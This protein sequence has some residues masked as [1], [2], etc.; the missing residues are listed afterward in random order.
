MIESI[1]SIDKAAMLARV[2]EI[3]G[4]ITEIENTIGVGKTF[5]ATLDREIERQGALTNPMPIEKFIE[6]HRK[7][8]AINANEIVNAAKVAE[9]LKAEAAAEEPVIEGIV[10]AAFEDES[11]DADFDSAIDYDFYDFTPARQNTSTEEMITAAARR[12]GVDPDLVRAIGTAESNLDQSARSYV[13]AVG[14]MQ[15]MPETAENL[16]VNPYDKR[17]NIEGGAKYIRQMLDTFNGNLHKA[18]AA[19]NAGPG[20]VQKYGGIPPYAETQ[21]YVGRVMDFYVK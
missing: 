6:L 9:A 17:Q 7:S 13:G 16:G 8:Q 21:S 18:I 10:D 5:Q 2:S 19:Y 15:L 11:F 3:Q 14:V 4:R 20:A 12:H 1:Q